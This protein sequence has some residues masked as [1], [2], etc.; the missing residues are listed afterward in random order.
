[1]SVCGDEE[2]LVFD[3]SV[4]DSGGVTLSH[5]IDHLTEQVARLGLRHQ[6]PVGDVIEQIL[7]GL[8]ALHD[9]DKA[10]GELEPGDE[11]DDARNVRDFPQ[12]ANLERYS[13]T[14]DL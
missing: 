1:M 2:V 14:I 6:L 4:D 13:L 7:D 12:K 8:R 5:H 11:L 9:D 3:V 10:I